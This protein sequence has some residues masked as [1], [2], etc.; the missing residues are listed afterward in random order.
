[1]RKLGE[2]IDLVLG[3]CEEALKSMDGDLVDLTVTSPPYDNLCSYKDTNGEWK[4]EKWKR[5]IKELY[6]V[7]KSGGVVVWVVGDATVNGSETGTSF[8]QALWA[9][10]CGFNIH[11]TMIYYKS[12]LPLTHNRYEQSFEYMFV[13]SKGKP[14]TF[15]GL[16][17]ESK[18][19][20][21]YTSRRIRQDGENLGHRSEKWKV[22]DLKLK[23]NVWLIQNGCNKSTTD[24][25]AY[26]HPSIFPEKL[27]EDHVLSWSN[28]GDLVLDPFMG[29]GTT[30]KMAKLLNRRFIGIEKVL[31]YLEIA[32]RRIEGP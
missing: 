14:L 27:A 9:K 18:N 23:G 13:L 26:E 11:D 1:M 17:E 8:K 20:G 7:T 31:E 22:N 28:E 6:R 24:K 19:K 29:S 21:T 12:N 4:E 32:K 3:D 15:N 16:K 25:Y 2:G 5:I 30:G 10:E